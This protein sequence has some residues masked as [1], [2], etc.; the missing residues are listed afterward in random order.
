MVRWLIFVLLLAV[1]AVGPARGDD[2]AGQVDGTTCDDG[3]PCTRD[4][5]C[6]GETC[7]GTAVDDG[8]SCDDGNPCTHT[9]RCTAGTCIGTDPVVCTASDVCHVSGTC[10][11]GT[12]AC[13]NPTAPDTKACDDGNA[14]TRTDHCAAGVCTGTNPVVC[15]ASEVCHFV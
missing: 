5:A 6:L 4:D 9:D 2:C 13:S 10:D 14:C 11:P 15:T 1:A 12:G 3:N 8:T 7:V